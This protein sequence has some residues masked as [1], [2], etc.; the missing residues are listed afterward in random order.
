MS[1]LSD[2]LARFQETLFPMIEISVQEPLTAR[3]KQFVYTLDIVQVERFIAS[4]FLQRMGR[5]RM[6]RRAIARAFI[7]KAIYDLPTTELLI[8]MLQS[9]PVLRKLCGF[10]RRRDIP[11]AATFSRAFE[12]FALMKLGDTVHEALVR[13]YVADRVVMHVSRDSTEVSAREKP[14]RKAKPAPKPVRKRG[15]P[16]ADSPRQL[17]EPTRLEKQYDLTPQEALAELKAELKYVCDVGAKADS[18]GNLHYWTGWKTHIDWADGGI[19]LS[20]A[21]A[22]SKTNSGSGTCEFAAI[23]RRTCT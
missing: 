9:Q 13:T 14:A 19:P 4:P 10:E 7:A 11:S 2:Y 3:Q 22:A 17:P 21:T 12:H 18:K 6:D 16:R 1:I 15:R 20:E 23:R 8:E 5:K